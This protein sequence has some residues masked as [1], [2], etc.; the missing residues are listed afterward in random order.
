M[1]RTLKRARKHNSVRAIFAG[2]ML[3]FTACAEDSAPRT[4]AHELEVL[5]ARTDGV[6]G[7]CIS[8]AGRVS[9][10]NGDRPFPMQSV[11]K[12]LAA[13]AALDAVDR[14]RFGINE[15][16]VLRREDLSLFVQP[17]A[18]RIDADG[19]DTYFGDLIFHAVVQSD[20]AATDFIIG[21]LGGPA[22][23]Q[24]FIT[25]T[26]IEGVRV[27]RDERRLQ[28]EILG[29]EWRAEFTDPDILSRAIAAVP[30]DV[31]DA[32]YQAFRADIR[33]TA[34]PRAMLQLLQRLSDG[35]LLSEHSTHFLLET[36][37]ATTTG[38][39]R[40]KAGV[41]PGWSVAHK[42]GSSGVWRGLAAATND[43]G[44]MI[45][46][47]GSRIVIAAFLAD[48]SAD[49]SERAAVLADAARIAVAHHR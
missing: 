46:P 25:R 47:D 43:V 35:A 7:V 39:D 8:D 12:L 24:D 21:A 17:L 34:T 5:D 1:Y 37:D 4:M 19:Y 22:A 36:M 11:M 48:S 32:H 2:V 38:P 20:N 23:V 45:A 28:T 30:E 44:L 29:L 16:V 10:V 9:C 27:D 6:L 3:M 33:D 18:E 26:G 13:M 31:R 42:T 40:L 41:P 15:P 14:G 49:E